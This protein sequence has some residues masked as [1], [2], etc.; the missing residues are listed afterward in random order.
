[1]WIFSKKV[2]LVVLLLFS[3][4]D[5]IYFGPL[6]TLSWKYYDFIQK[7]QA[8][9]YKFPD[10]FIFIEI[11]QKSLTDL[12]DSLGRWPWPRA[13]HSDLLKKIGADGAQS[14][15]FDLLFNER[16]IQNPNSDAEFNSELSQIK[17]FF[18]SIKVSGNTWLYPQVIKKEFWNTGHI[19]FAYDQDGIGRRFDFKNN[20]M[21]S[22]AYNVVKSIDS[23]DEKKWPNNALLRF[24][25]SKTLKRYSYSE[26]LQDN[27][28]IDVK[29]SVIVI[30]ASA[31]GLGDFSATSLDLHQSG[32]EILI[33]TI[34]NL[35]EKSWINQ[36]SDFA[37]VVF[38]LS[39]FLI[40]IFIYSRNYFKFKIYLL[41]TVS[42]VVVLALA[43]Y[44]LMRKFNFYLQGSVVA[45]NLLPLITHFIFESYQIEAE[46]RRHVMQTFS[47][48]LDPKIIKKI[49][50]KKEINVGNPAEKCN[51]TL[52]FS[53]IRNFT[54]ISE[55][56]DPEKVASLLNE[57]FTQQVEIIFKYGGTLDKFIGDAIMAFWGAPYQQKA[58]NDLAIQ[59][60][61]E[62]IEVAK[63]LNLDIGIGIHY[64][65]AIVGLI[66]S[67]QRLEYTAIGDNVNLASRIEG[68]TKGVSSILLS[69]DVINEVEDKK[70]FKFKECGD[71]K[72]KGRNSEVKLYSVCL[73]EGE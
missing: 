17:S 6:K 11:D 56:T 62:M 55:K 65:E 45:L 24:Y 36:S 51:I 38:Y 52:L 66:G 43:D 61:L 3:A 2:V 15:V 73:A 23:Q 21:N 40:F 35:Y 34:L 5:Y 49:I 68:L 72:V 67:P 50:S 47:R 63:K 69:Q 30:G 31:D 44:I 42:L 26:L 10:K 22:L 46:S 71:F 13:V 18:P 27:V 7:I 1:M 48:F 70:K 60:A 14:V 20:E 37:V 39:L 8:S 33:T 59:A 54:S 57:Y 58:G 32:P 16:D 4:F 53:D 28:N 9:D 29:G 12:A 41:I 25:D 64:G 19:H